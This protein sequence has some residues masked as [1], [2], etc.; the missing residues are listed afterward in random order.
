MQVFYV[1]FPRYDVSDVVSEIQA[2]NMATVPNFESISDKCLQSWNG[3]VPLRT[4][5]S[6]QKHN[7]INNKEAGLDRNLRGR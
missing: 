5:N 6:L 7:N 1:Q 3:F 2:T 4:I